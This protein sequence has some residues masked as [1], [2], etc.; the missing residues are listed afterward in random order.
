MSRLR[1]PP[2]SVAQRETGLQV[3]IKATPVVATLR[4]FLGQFNSRKSK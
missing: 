1:N 2:N 4:I 3:F